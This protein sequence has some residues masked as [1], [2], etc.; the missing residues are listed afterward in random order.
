MSELKSFNVYH[1]YLDGIS[2][3]TYEERG[4]L[5]TA[6]LRYSALGEETELT[7]NERF[8]FPLMRSQIDRDRKT[9]EEKSRR[10]SENGRKGAQARIQ[11]QQKALESISAAA[12]TL[13]EIR[14]FCEENSLKVN[15]QR[16]FD[17]FQAGGWRDSHGNKVYNWQQKL[18]TW[19]LYETRLPSDS[20][21][22][23][24][25]D[26]PIDLHELKRSFDKI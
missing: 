20:P 11:K 1:S 7:G 18:L 24:P 4:R 5:L 6:L 16:F 15:P 19:E 23:S 9:Y 13:E 3:L 12:P 22:A 26:Y 25:A 10:N 21:A 14:S 17:Y 8:V 2:L